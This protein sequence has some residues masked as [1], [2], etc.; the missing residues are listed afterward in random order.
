MKLTEPAKPKALFKKRALLFVLFLGV[1]SFF[2]D[3]VAEGSK[4]ISG[5]Y[6]EL[7]GASAAAVGF[8]VGF[9]EFLSYILRIISGYYVD[10]TSKYWVAT[11]LGYLLNLIA[12]PLL[13]IVT[14]WKIAALLIL[15]ERIGKAIRTPPRDAMLSYASHK[16]GRGRGFGIHQLLDQIGGMTGPLIIGVAL[17]YEDS[18]HF[19]Y[20]LLAIPAVLSLSVLFIA[21]KRYPHPQHLEIEPVEIT[22][23]TKIPHLL[24]VY[25]IGA[26]FLAAGY[27]DFPLIAF[28]FHKTGLLQPF[29]IPLFYA[30][31]M[32]FSA[33][34]A[35]LFG[36]IYDRDGSKTLVIAIVLSALSPVC[37]FLG[38][39]K[40]AL[41]GM[42]LWGIGMGAQRTLLKAYVGDMVSK[43]VRGSAYGMFYA[44]YGLAWFL[45]SWL[46]G[47]LYDISLM[48]LIAFSTIAQLVA[49]PFILASAIQHERA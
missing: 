42:I 10:K 38:D 35:L 12:I 11:G 34:S 37:A 22:S 28:H 43:R 2:S 15:I 26:M 36:F 1:V 23:P 20:A 5:P 13:A 14:S 27:A 8:I 32:G 16:M 33:I 25:L 44:G 17:F 45:G 30:I 41:L 49:I 19:G 48:W 7:L 46:I 24:W 47:I 21:K 18:Y 39:F 40:L 31:S 29:W 6:L 3:I 4:S 9:G